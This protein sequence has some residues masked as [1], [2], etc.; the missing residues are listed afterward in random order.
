MDSTRRRLKKILPVCVFFLAVS[1]VL[2]CLHIP[3]GAAA[4]DLET[5]LARYDSYDPGKNMLAVDGYENY[6]VHNGDGL[7]ET[8]YTYENG[9]LT[10]SDESLD[11]G[12]VRVTNEIVERGTVTDAAGV[13]HALSDIPMLYA[14]KIMFLDVDGVAWHG[15]GLAFG[16]NE[17]GYTITFRA[18]VNGAAT[19][20][21]KAK[22]FNYDCNA[23]DVS[24]AG[25]APT[26]MRSYEFAVIRN[27]LNYKFFIDGNSVGFV[28]L[29]EKSGDNRNCLQTAFFGVNTTAGCS[30]RTEEMRLV[31]L[32][33]IPDF[34]LD[35]SSDALNALAEQSLSFERTAQPATHSVESVLQDGM[36]WQKRENS[37]WRYDS[38]AESG[39]SSLLRFH[40]SVSDAGENGSLFIRVRENETLYTAV[41]LTAQSVTLYLGSESDAQTVQ[42]PALLQESE[43]SI[44]SSPSR[45]SVW[46]DGQKVASA[47]VDAAL[48][49]SICT[50]TAQDAAVQITELSRQYMGDVLFANP[51]DFPEDQRDPDP[52]LNG[53]DGTFAS[54]FDDRLFIVLLI[55]GIVYAA[56]AITG[57]TW[58]LV[59]RQKNKKS[60]ETKG[61]KEEL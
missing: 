4:S 8:L 19:M 58:F 22:T 56:L 2:T 17:S 52:N 15:G 48:Q 12:T 7:D 60:T 35:V 31:P 49:S 57:T 43:I 29:P 16:R 9:V 1:L 33:D 30:I 54:L 32:A 38:V 18:M 59:R 55:F 39:F 24:M 37:T 46:I 36:L 10:I 11:G 6:A 25:Y 41:K 40:L 23:M 50:F 27:G 3:V 13:Q 44:L 5:E 51:N 53:G 34:E 47:E 28:N 42:S 45:L 20:N 61:N 21:M 14:A 26:A